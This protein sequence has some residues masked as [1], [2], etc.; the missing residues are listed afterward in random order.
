MK[1][2]LVCGEAQASFFYMHFL[3]KL[4]ERIRAT[5]RLMITRLKNGRS[6]EIASH[7][8]VAQSQTQGTHKGCQGTH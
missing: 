8:S 3:I 4:L 1:F 2:I 6:V 5:P 7:E